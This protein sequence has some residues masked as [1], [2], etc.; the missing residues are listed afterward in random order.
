MAANCR[1]KNPNECRVHGTNG[2][3]DRLQRVADHA[4]K[5]GDY[6]LYAKTRADMD[7]LQDEE[8]I[9]VK[10]VEAAASMRH[11]AAGWEKTSQEVKTMA[12]ADARKK[13]EIAAPFLIKGRVTNAAITAVAQHLW[14]SR[15]NGASWNRAAGN[16]RD[17]YMRNAQ[18]FLKV[19]EPHLREL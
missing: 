15:N 3:Y 17:D 8:Y 5:N 19:A 13:L 2:Q 4:A 6:E 12:R 16:E 7:A 14:E 11:S 9:P 10:A 1:A 18:R